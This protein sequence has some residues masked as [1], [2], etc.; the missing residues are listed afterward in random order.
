VVVEKAG[1]SV[2]TADRHTRSEWRLAVLPL[3]DDVANEV[4]PKVASAFAQ[5]T[6]PENSTKSR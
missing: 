5:R 3:E 4:L 1:E 6:L 2:F